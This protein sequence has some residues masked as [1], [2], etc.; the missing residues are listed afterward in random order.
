VVEE[1][2]AVGLRERKKQRTRAMLVDAA[3]KL[4]LRQGYY[5]TTVEQIAAAADVS[6]RTFSR[7]FATKEAV[8][9]TVMDDLVDAAAN[10]L[11]AVPSSVP[12]LEALC[13]AHSDMLRRVPAGRVPGL[14]AAKVALMVNV[15]SSA[16]ELRTAATMARPY[17]ILRDVA[18][19]LGAAPSDGRVMMVCGIWASI[20]ATAWA[21]LASEACEV[22]KFPVVMADR[23]DEMFADFVDLAAVQTQ[24]KLPSN[25]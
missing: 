4:C 25:A 11:S 24:S 19:R 13:R 20:V 15:L 12:P 3:V 6:A 5:G 9:V 16:G 17:P 22:N 8:L 14:N 7:Y 23:L 18:A 10:E 1:P 2:P 21:N